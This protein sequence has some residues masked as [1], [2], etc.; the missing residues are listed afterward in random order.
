MG[1]PS[2]KQVVSEVPDLLARLLEMPES[3]I[4]VRAGEKSSGH[5]FVISAGEH[6]FLVES[7][8]SSARAPLIQ[9]ISRLEE[10]RKKQGKDII[11]LLV[12]PYMGETGRRLCEEHEITWLDLSGNARIKAPGLLINVEGKP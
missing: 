5:D 10:H 1:I 4:A 11:P 8:G 12:V 6:T 9:A 2:E 3:R 7:K